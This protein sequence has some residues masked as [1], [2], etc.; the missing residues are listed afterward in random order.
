[1]LEVWNFAT[2]EH[3]D[4]AS[5][6]PF[7]NDIYLSK[8]GGSHTRSTVIF[9]KL[10]NYCICVIILPLTFALICVDELLYEVAICPHLVP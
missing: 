10:M 1:M 6:L 4:R 3:C 8:D 2:R 9:E 7:G 5:L